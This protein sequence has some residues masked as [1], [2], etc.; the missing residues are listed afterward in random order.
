M[1]VYLL[2]EVSLTVFH[3]DT[4]NTYTHDHSNWNE[5]L[6]ALRA[7]DFDRIIELGDVVKRTATYLSTNGQ[8]DIEIIDNLLVYKGKE[9][10]NSLARRILTMH[11]EG[12]SITPMVNFLRN[13]MENPSSRARNQ[14]YDFLEVNNVPITADGCFMAYKLVNNAYKDCHTNSI[15]NSIGASPRMSRYDVDDD[16]TNTCSSG[17][18]VCG[19][20]YL[21]HFHGTHLMAC[22]V[23][24]ADVVSIPIDYNNSK[25]R[26]CGY[27]VASELPMDLVA[28]N[29]EY[30]ESSVCDEDE[31]YDYNPD[32]CDED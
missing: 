25:M 10:N 6:E 26:V 4:V 5:M 8:T 9:I 13:L 29:K 15:D 32:E 21:R 30:W 17:F 3:N 11:S 7:E 14:L 12:F 31:E 16:P 22:K 18:H 28:G 27:T 19:L 24:P 20:G 23:N 1:S 2:S